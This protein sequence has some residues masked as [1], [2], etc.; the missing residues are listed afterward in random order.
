[1][2]EILLTPATIKSILA[3]SIRSAVNTLVPTMMVAVLACGLSAL[4]LV[5]SSRT[6]AAEDSVLKQ[7]VE[8]GSLN[9]VLTD[10][11]DS[12]QLDQQMVQAI[13]SL[14]T[15][16]RAVGLSAP[17]DMVNQSTG[18]GG[19]A[20]P[21]WE[22]AG[23]IRSVAT[24]T[25]GRLPEEGEALVSET[26]RRELGLDFPAG[27]VDRRSGVHG[28]SVSDGVPVVGSFRSLEPFSMLDS[29]IIVAAGP[30]S[31]LQSISIVL[32]SVDVAQPS[33]AVVLGI[34]APRDYATLRV[35]SPT[36][37]AE[38]QESI[39]ADLRASSQGLLILSGTSGS[40]LVGIVVLSDVLIRRKDLG[41]RRALGATRWAVVL[42]VVTRTALAATLGAMI[43]LLLALVLT[44]E[45]SR[46]TTSLVAAVLVLSV[47]LASVAA[48]GP[49]AFAAFRDPVRILRTP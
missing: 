33:Q 39:A 6:Q 26:A 1:M 34:V 46:P 30:R 14:S 36:A 23:D 5:T 37:L 40:L 15:V 45:N 17:T 18:E 4:V 43:G 13:S 3:E 49:A 44:P 42:L 16:V 24:I 28:L 20:V 12:G 21:A 31:R 19:Q 22:V 48:L 47:I 38:L 8:A 41:R 32:R 9:L 10:T 7:I 2:T 35:V 11:A 29:G 25:G 27:A